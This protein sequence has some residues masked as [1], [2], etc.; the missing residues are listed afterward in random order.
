M[1]GQHE[2]WRHVL[3][4]KSLD[5]E[6]IRGYS[7]SKLKK[8]MDKWSLSSDM[9]IA[10]ESGARHCTMNPL[11]HDSEN[12]PPEPSSPFGTTFYTPRNRLKVAFRV[13]SQI[14]WENF[15]KGRLSQD[16]IACMDYHFQTNGSKLTGQEC[17]TKLI[18]GLWEHMDR[19]WTYRNNRYHENTSQQSAR[20]KTEALDRRYEE[21]WV[22]H[23]G[24]VERLHKFE[25]KQH[26]QSNQRC[27][28]HLN[29][30]EQDLEWVKLVT[31]QLFERGIVATALFVL[32]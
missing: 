7:W 9:W 29:S 19:I 13:Q 4:C 27:I 8:Q 17:I 6:M 16:W 2:D 23:A 20:Y 10:M 21:I 28:L 30:W 12:M 11:K 15:L 3:T 18:L 25:T 5:A 1:C 32:V 24:L 22:K 14:G 26:H 31:S